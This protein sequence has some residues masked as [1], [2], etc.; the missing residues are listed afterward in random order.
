MND[1]RF[2]PEKAAL[3]VSD[4]RFKKLPPDEVLSHLHIRSTDTVADLGAGNGF[5]TIPIA[6]ITEKTVFAVDI[7]PKMLEMLEERAREEQIENIKYVI[8]DLED[9]HINDHTVHKILVS[10]VIHEVSNLQKAIDDMKRILKRDGKLLILEWEAIETESGPP[11][12]ERIPSNDLK[13]ILEN[14]G[15]ETTMFHLSP[16]QYV[17]LARTNNS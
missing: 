17:I 6:K 9:I 11:L 8:S 4:E 14:N 16:D 15:F 13:E 12:H 3:L 10:F 2:K 1:K 5:F 7:E